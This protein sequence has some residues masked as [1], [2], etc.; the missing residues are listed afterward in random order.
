MLNLLRTRDQKLALLEFEQIK[1][2]EQTKTLQDTIITLQTCIR[3]KND[4]HNEMTMKKNSLQTEVKL[5]LKQT[6]D[7]KAETAELVQQK[8]HL[9]EEDTALHTKIKET[10]DFN[11]MMMDK[12]SLQTELNTLNRQDAAL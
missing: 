10:N 12:I 2:E 1:Y 4:S 6:T 3:T 11:T 8:K 7:I 5:L 9:Q